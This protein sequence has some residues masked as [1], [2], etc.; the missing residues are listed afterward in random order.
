MLGPTTCGLAWPLVCASA[1]RGET[2]LQILP[3]GGWRCYPFG[4][5]PL[6]SLSFAGAYIA[7]PSPPLPCAPFW[8]SSFCS[9]RAQRRHASWLRCALHW[10]SIAL[11][12]AALSRRCHLVFPFP[13]ISAGD[14]LGWLLACCPVPA[15]HPSVSFC[16]TDLNS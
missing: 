4:T 10:I 1:S 3:G 12:L 8:T 6:A 14:L 15:V 5:P 2:F 9:L 13:A 16:F 7:L 11:R